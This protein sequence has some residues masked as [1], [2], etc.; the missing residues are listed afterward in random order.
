[1]KITKE[2]LD[3]LPIIERPLVEALLNDLETINSLG[4]KKLYIDWQD[5]HNEYSPERTDPCPDYYGYYTLRFVSNNDIV[6]V[7]MDLDTLDTVMCVLY[8][9]LEYEK[10]V[11]KHSC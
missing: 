5:W 9:Y 1:M 3:K 6:G 11:A 2:N 10:E 8:N 4:T 7:E